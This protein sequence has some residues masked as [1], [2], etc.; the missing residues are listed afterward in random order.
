MHDYLKCGGSR[1][2]MKPFLTAVWSD[3]ILASFA[4]PDHV[5]QPYLRPGLTLDRWDG[6]AWCSLVAFDFRKTTVLSVPMPP[7]LGVRDFP[8]FNLRFY[9]REG[10]RRGVVFVRELV[11]SWFLAGAA[12]LTYNEP[13]RTTCMT[14]R[15]T[16]IGDLRR[17]RHDFVW[18]GQRQ[19]IAVSAHG[20]AQAPSEDTFDHWVKEQA[21][22]F[23]RH[24]SGKAIR[25]H[26][27]HPTWAA[28]P[29]EEYAIRVDTG[30]MY[31]PPWR[32]LEERAPDSVV[33]AEGSAVS[34]DPF[35][36]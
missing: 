4:V 11:P 21:W 18:E 34:I 24:R 29:V 9:A 22:G 8:E 16:Q 19:T 31:G 2:R 15:V 7:G 26:V 23:G 35:Q 27:Q 36:T 14:S 6:S 13:Y 17:V 1:H 10:D 32:F 28:Y 30:R 20:P 3:L 25:Y 5:L 12:R 33:L